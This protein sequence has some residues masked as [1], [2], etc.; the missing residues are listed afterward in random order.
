MN[1]TRT[2]ISLLSLFAVALSAH[3]QDE[4]KA[5]ID[6]WQT[7]KVEAARDPFERTNQFTINFRNYT[8]EEW[9]Y[10]LRGA[11]VISP[12]GGKRARHAGTDIKTFPNDSVRAAFAG[13]V[14]I[15][16]P[17]Y[18]YGNCVV[19]R[20]ANGLET[21]YSHNSKNLVKVGHW[22]HAGEVI[23]LVGR[24]GRAT[25]EHVHFETRI[26]G[27]AFDSSIIFDHD[28]N[29]LRQDIFVFE[30]RPNGTLR[31]SQVGKEGQVKQV[32][33]KPIPKLPRNQIKDTIQVEPKVA[34]EDTVPPIAG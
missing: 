25:T 15:S 3:A 4:E 10:P 23:A 22:V 28:N 6:E 17:H 32:E 9:S 2:I 18:G 21:L 14:V 29:K 31:I 26:K 27:K 34:P 16:A 1:I 33:A 24:T 7:L 5:D 8:I 20:H 30:K 19:L 13:E 12:F 11:H